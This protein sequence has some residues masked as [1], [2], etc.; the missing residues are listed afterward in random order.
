MIGTSVGNFR[1]IRK[2]GQGG[3]GEVLLAEHKDIQTKVAMQP[4]RAK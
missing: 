2:L 3:M 4:L 1:V